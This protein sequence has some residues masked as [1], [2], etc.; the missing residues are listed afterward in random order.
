MKPIMNKHNEH[1]IRIKYT[2]PL[3]LNLGCFDTKMDGFQGLD[4]LDCGQE[5]V[6]D[7]TLGLPFPD[8]SVEEIF[9]CHFIEHIADYDL[10]NLFNEILRVCKNGTILTFQCPHS[11]RD[12]AYYMDHVSL[13]NEQKVRGFC[14]GYAGLNKHFDIIYNRRDGRDLY[15]QLK[16]VK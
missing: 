1:P 7:A 9:C 3:R 13:W 8:D 14:Q 12:E 10:L 11:E 2:F 16:V 15:F 6:W 4:V 5:I